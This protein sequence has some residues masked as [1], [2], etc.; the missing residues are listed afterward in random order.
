MSPPRRLEIRDVRLPR[1]LRLRALLLL[2]PAVLVVVFARFGRGDFAQK[3]TT[4]Q[5]DHQ[6]DRTTL[7]ATKRKLR[8]F[9]NLC[10][11]VGRVAL[12]VYASA[13]RG[14][15]VSIKGMGLMS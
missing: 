14:R 15:T 8:A 4:E 1:H 6:R 13:I 7:V 5:V 10:G 11:V 9:Q 3:R 2:L 12:T